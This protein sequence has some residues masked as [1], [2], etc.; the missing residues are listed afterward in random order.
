MSIFTPAKDTLNVVMLLLPDASLMSL[1]AT[2]DTMRAAN[3]ISRRTLFKWK[4]TTLD[5]KPARLSCGV[6]IA[7]D[8]AF[9]SV[10]EQEKG[11]LMIV[12]AFRHEQHINQARLKLIRQ[13]AK[14]FDCV[15]GIESG[16]WVMARAG[17]L[18]GHQATVHWED[19]EEFQA[20]FPHICVLPDRF[21]VEGRY[22]TTG[23]SSPSFDLMLYLIRARYGHTLAL[24]VASVFIYE[25]Q[26]ASD[27]QP[28]V[29]LGSMKH[30]EPRLAK[31]IGLMETHI[32]LPQS[33]ADIAEQLGI[34]QR[35]LEKL[36]KQKLAM[37]PYQ[38][39][40]RLRL[41]SARRLV[42]DT[43]LSMQEI[44]IRTGFASL[45]VFSRE[46]KQYFQTSPSQ[47]RN[48]RL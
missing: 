23:G 13:K 41:Q 15:G 7:P 28:L 17:M 25:G 18:G 46:F 20:R 16:G 3:R 21:V 30:H 19:L 38:Y 5:G 42:L 12:A 31:A 24:E 44:A 22:F 11:L 29:S 34:S 45:A 37:S 47:Y 4:V 2:L 43:P 9:E 26:H 48:R 6:K 10:S 33:I 40:K 32:D 8:S 27:P 1:S 36:F 14:S 35:M 39:Y